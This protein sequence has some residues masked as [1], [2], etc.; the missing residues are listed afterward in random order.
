MEVTTEWLNKNEHRRFPIATNV[1]AKDDDG[2]IFPDNLIADLSVMYNDSVPGS[3]GPYLSSLII[4]PSLVSVAISLD[5]AVILS[6]SFTKPAPVRVAVPLQSSAVNCSGYIAFGL[7]INDETGSYTFSSADQSRLEYKATKRFSE[8]PIKS[9]TVQGNS[10]DTLDGIVNLRSSDPIRIVHV[11][12]NVVE[13]SLRESARQQF[14]GPCD[15]AL[16]PQG[17]GPAPLRKI[18]GVGPDANGNLFVEVE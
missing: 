1:S 15:D 16:N 11:G 6:G 8:L 13:I 4:G 12:D 2:K 14:L 10:G 7:D 18:N 5:G 17:C 3:P 9:M